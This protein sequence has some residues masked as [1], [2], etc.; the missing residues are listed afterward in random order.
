ML[1]Y[2]NHVTFIAISWD[3][4]IT[5]WKEGDSDYWVTCKGVRIDKHWS[6]DSNPSLFASKSIS[7]AA[8]ACIMILLFSRSLKKFSKSTSDKDP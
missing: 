5:I 1:T 2:L 8:M 4:S 3:M 6:L 7:F